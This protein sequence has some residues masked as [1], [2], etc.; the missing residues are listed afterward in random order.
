LRIKQYYFS[1][2]DSGE[3]S[4]NE[5]LESYPMAGSADDLDQLDEPDNNNETEMDC[6][7]LGDDEGK[8]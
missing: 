3:H 1:S 2:L 4:E 5:E 6:E 8:C 7:D